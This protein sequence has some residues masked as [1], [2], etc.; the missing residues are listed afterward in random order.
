[1][2][3]TRH[4]S[5]DDFLAIA[6]P[7]L[8][9]AEAENNLILGVA[10]GI[11]RNPSAARDPY[12][13]TV[14]DGPSVLA[15]AVYIAPYK[16]VITS[17]GQ[18]AID[19]LAQDVFDAIPQVGAVTGPARSAADFAVAWSRRSGFEPIAG[20]RFRI[21][22]VR[23]LQEP[24]PR[25]ASGRFRPALGADQDLLAS[26]MIAFAHEAGLPEQI[27]APRVVADAIGRGRLFVWEDDQTVSMA[28]WAGK[29]PNG[30]RINLVYTP[31]ERRRQGYGTACVSAITSQLLAEGHAFCWLY[32]DQSSSAGTTLFTRLGYRPVSDVAE[33][34]LKPVVSR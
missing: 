19:V 13:A 5:A 27:D 7:L 6:E 17:A 8:M 25:S 12:L 34:Y 33:Y 4:L 21:H 10:R 14:S 20:M 29:T 28:G 26:W 16:V 24:A 22:E 30:V 3:V 11:A 18:E 23:A 9:L 31:K 1:M 2:I 32:T 15:C